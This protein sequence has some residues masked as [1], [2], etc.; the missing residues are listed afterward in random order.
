MRERDVADARLGEAFEHLD[1]ALE[2]VPAF[3]PHQRRPLAGAREPDH[4]GGGVRH[5]DAVERGHL[6]LGLGDHVERALCGRGR[7]TVGARDVDREKRRVEPALRHLREVDVL[8]ARAR[9]VA[10]AEVVAVVEHQ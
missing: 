10:L 8:I 2:R 7:L 1:G 3:E 9:R 6:P 5:L 4:V